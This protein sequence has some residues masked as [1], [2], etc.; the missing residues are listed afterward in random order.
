MVKD[1]KVGDLI[2]IACCQNCGLVQLKDVPN[3][4]DLLS[5]ISRNIELSI[6]NRKSL[7]L[8]MCIGQGHLQYRGLKKLHLS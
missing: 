5:S 8:N 3:E 4:Q 1:A 6:E 2:S 7:A